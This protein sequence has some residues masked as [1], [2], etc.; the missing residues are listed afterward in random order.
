MAVDPIGF[1]PFCRE[2]FEGETHCP[3]HELALVPW[4]QLGPDPED[5]ES[6]PRVV[7]ESPLA[8]LSPG[9][10]RGWLMAGALLTGMSLFMEMLPGVNGGRGLRTY[11]LAVS[12]PSMWTPLAVAFLVIYVLRTR[13][14]PRAMRSLRLALPFLA[15]VS[16]LTLGWAFLRLW[17]GA[18]M[19]A[20]GDRM[21]GTD[22]GLA[23]AALLLGSAC[24][25][26]GG[27]R[28]GR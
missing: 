21:V 11:E 9:R 18:P 25:F 10:G 27:L 7:D 23:A 13:R 15:M 1:C 14:T 3:E 19:Y 8:V 4:D 6:D 12:L 2:C 5:P 28:F 16:P 24:L 22:P 26:V 17:S 20:A